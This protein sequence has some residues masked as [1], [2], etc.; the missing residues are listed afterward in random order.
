MLEEYFYNDIQKVRFVLNDRDGLFYKEDTEAKKA[1]ELF[2]REVIDDEDRDFYILNPDIA[3]I[4]DLKDEDI[5]KEYLKNL[6]N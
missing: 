6:I 1:Y 3:T 2:L 5:C 4:I